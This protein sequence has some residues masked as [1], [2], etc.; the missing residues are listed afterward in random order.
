MNF[1]RSIT[2]NGQM[3]EVF[4]RVLIIMAIVMMFFLPEN[5]HALTSLFKVNPEKIVT[6]RVNENY[7]K[8]FNE[9]RNQIGTISRYR[10]GFHVTEFNTF[11]FEESVQ[12]GNFKDNGEVVLF[13]PGNPIYISKFET[14]GNARS[15]KDAF[16]LLHKNIREILIGKGLIAGVN[17]DQSFQEQPHE[18]RNSGYGPISIRPRDPYT[19]AYNDWKIWL[20]EEF[21]STI[22]F[23]GYLTFG[24]HIIEIGYGPDEHRFIYKRIKI[25]VG[26]AN[27]VI[28]LE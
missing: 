21:F 7:I 6:E 1:S 11:I 25:N 14:I 23:N 8:V 16:I 15:Y 10:G 2:F 17:T 19:D 28:Y 24:E 13:S 9:F 12:M 4:K 18:Q 3:I 22:P 20:D 27:A 5:V 26:E